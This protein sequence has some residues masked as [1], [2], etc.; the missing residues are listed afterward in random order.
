MAGSFVPAACKMSRHNMVTYLKFSAAASLMTALFLLLLLGLSTP[1][2]PAAA[3]PDS[4]GACVALDPQNLLQ[5]PSFE[6]QYEAYVPN[7]PIPQ[8]PDG[9]CTSVRTPAGWQ[10]WW[11]NK[12]SDPLYYKMPE[13]T[14]AEHDFWYGPPRVRTGES[15]QQLFTLFSTHE[16]GVYQQIATTPGVTYCLSAWGHSWTAQDDPIAEKNHSS[17]PSPQGEGDACSGPQDGNLQQKIGLDPTGGT[18]PDSADIVWSTARTQYDSYAIFE[19]MATAQGDT[20]TVFLYS[21]PQHPVKHNNAYWDDA[22]A[23]APRMSTAGLK[24]LPVITLASD[25]KSVSAG[26]TITLSAGMADKNWTAVVDTGGG[27]APAVNPL[28]GTSGGTLDYSFSTNGLSTGVY[29]ATVTVSSDTPTLGSPQS[30][31]L[32]A[33]IAEQIYTTYLPA[34]VRK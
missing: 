5:N 30:Y 16:A 13:F 32:T 26:G 33:I 11:S 20:M 8:C 12:G 9:I 17:C 6:G 21:N 3:E 15:A 2:G 1:T 24:D 7:P 28:S 29:T 10:P 19:V 18:D 31:D 23:S 25:P 27:L 22:V 4:E 34:I 14:A